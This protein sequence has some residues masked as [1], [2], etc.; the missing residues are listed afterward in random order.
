M[1]SRESNPG[2]LA[3][4]LL[5]LTIGLP[6]LVGIFSISGLYWIYFEVVL[7]RCFS[8]MAVTPSFVTFCR[9][10]EFVRIEE[11][12]GSLFLLVSSLSVH[13]RD[14]SEFGVSGS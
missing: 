7:F 14:F 6:P 11:L 3:C 8:F 9:N 1:S 10:F 12:Q 13:F 2:P 5:A 4:I